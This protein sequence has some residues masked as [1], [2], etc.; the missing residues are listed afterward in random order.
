MERTQSLEFEKSE[1]MT[2][3]GNDIYKCLSI[4]YG[5]LY[6]LTYC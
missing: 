2:N 4:I 5:S 1:L 6:H 3:F